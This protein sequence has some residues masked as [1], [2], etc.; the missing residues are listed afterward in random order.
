VG[1]YDE[2]SDRF[3]KALRTLKQG[4]VRIISISQTKEMAE[5]VK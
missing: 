5:L 2:D 3:K 4:K 1:I